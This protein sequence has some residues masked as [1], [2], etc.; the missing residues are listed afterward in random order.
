MR[1]LCLPGGSCLNCS[2]GTRSA[3]QGGVTSGLTYRIISDLFSP[4]SFGLIED[5]GGSASP[6][7]L[8][9][10]SIP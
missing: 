8:A 5:G 10:E 7:S 4:L 9:S 2:R 1:F 3:L 6:E